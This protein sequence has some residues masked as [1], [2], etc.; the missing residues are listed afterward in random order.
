MIAPS[1]ENIENAA[2]RIKD[3]VRRTPCLRTRFIK[4]P[5]HTGPLM[6]KLE[7]LQV[8]GSFKARGANNAILQLDD[9]TLARGVI[10]AS[11]GNHGL[12][13]AYAARASGAN[14]VIYLP[15]RA[16]A[17]KADKL[18]AW[19]AQVIIEGLDFDDANEAAMAHGSRE[20]MTYLHPFNNPDIIGFKR[21]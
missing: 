1:F 13:V 21:K 8:T 5:I 4:D 2:E 18:R 12:A 16:P 3:R 15:E 11:G 7:S 19:G 9:A 14:A 20:N 10:T 6:L 17:E